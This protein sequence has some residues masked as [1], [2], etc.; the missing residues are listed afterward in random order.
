MAHSR[1]PDQTLS[2]VGRVSARKRFPFHAQ[3]FLL[4]FDGRH[5]P[6][7]AT[8]DDIGHDGI[9]ITT[10]H[11]LTEGGLLLLKLYTEKGLLQLAVRV[12]YCLNGFGIACKFIDVDSQQQTALSYLVALS[13]AAPVEHR[14]LRSG[15]EPPGSALPTIRM[16][17]VG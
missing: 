2:G 10:T 15:D 9:F 3:A 11:I 7:W 12:V 1:I 16:R 4:P 8:T 17:R 13:S 6:F 14:T 5:Q